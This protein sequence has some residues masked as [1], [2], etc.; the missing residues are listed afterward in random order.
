[1]VKESKERIKA[2]LRSCGISLPPRK[3]IL[4]LSPSDI[5]KIGTR[6]DLPMAVAILQLLYNPSKSVQEVFDNA[7]F[8]G[9]L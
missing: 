3:I 1:M 6:F 5:R 4:N 9:E 2:S 8:F 7:L